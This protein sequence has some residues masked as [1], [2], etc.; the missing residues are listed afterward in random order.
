METTTRRQFLDDYRTIRH[1]EGRGSEDPSY[2]LALPYRDL[3]GNN[4]AQ[5]EIRGKSY[6]HFER[7]IL[8]GLEKRL[9]RPLDILDLGAGNCW[10]SYRLSLRDHR[11]VA[12]DIFSDSR[13]G[14]LASRHYPR[15]FSVIEAQFDHL[16]FP[17]QSFDLAI[18]NASFHYS[19]DYHHTLR[20]LRRCLRP[21]GCF[22]IMDSPVYARPE[23]G[24]LM[25][26]ERR[27][28]FLRQYGFPSDALAS[29]EYLDEPMLQRLASELGI[30]WRM[31]RV[32]YGWNWFLRPWKARMQ[33][34]RPPSRFVILA[35]EFKEL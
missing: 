28:Q 21:K 27:E 4:S 12:L 18:F 15:R 23:H 32:W 3:N 34:R 9:G 10:M 25:R 13:D 22:V 26:A 1:A 33:K 5:W 29:L 19:S 2:Y 17:E 14:L 16:P 31:H 20:E 35:G 8:P 24:E 6:H 30:D 7:K 11:P